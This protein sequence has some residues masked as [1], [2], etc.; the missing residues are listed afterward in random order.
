MC[1]AARNCAHLS[2]G[3]A[4]KLAH[5]RWCPRLRRRARKAAR[6]HKAVASL[7][8]RFSHLMTRRNSKLSFLL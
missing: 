2:V 5:P 4:Q 3:W 6:T 7:E 8:R 1:L